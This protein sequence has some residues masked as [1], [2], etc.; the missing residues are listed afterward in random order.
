MALL[1]IPSNFICPP[2][3]FTKTLIK[4]EKSYFGQPFSLHHTG[5]RE[6]Q[7]WADSFNSR[8]GENFCKERVE[9]GKAERLPSLVFCVVGR[10]GVAF[11]FND[12]KTLIVDHRPISHHP[13]PLH[14]PLHQPRQSKM[15][16]I[17][18]EMGDYL[19]DN[20][21]W[22]VFAIPMMISYICL[23]FTLYILY[24]LIYPTIIPFPYAKFHNRSRSRLDNPGEY[25]D[26]PPPLDRPRLRKADDF[27]VIY[28]VDECRKTVV[29]AGSFNPPHRGHMGMVEFLSGEHER[30]VV[31]VGFNPGKRYDVEPEV[32]R[33]IVGKMCE[34]L[35]NVEVQLVE[36]LVWRAA[37]RRNAKV[38]YR[39]VRTWKRDGWS[40]LSLLWC[41]LFFPPI[42]GGI[43]PIPT[44]FLEGNPEFN[45][46]SSTLIRERCER[47]EEVGDLVPEAVVGLVKEAYGKKKR[48]GGESK[49]EK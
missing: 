27:P 8:G 36:G 13:S 28:E 11:L 14:Q 16:L 35:K 32:R 21:H 7:L 9:R 47:G 39:G 29:L 43:E 18:K 26:E 41:N 33:G 31:V 2:K 44:R 12:R 40:E 45:H 48:E 34:G 49:K 22:S 19:R 1:S 20:Y 25:V 46:I 23:G 5:N 24:N 15:E 6:A 10:R 38:L 3:K 30:V 42:L 17:S 4:T 37:S